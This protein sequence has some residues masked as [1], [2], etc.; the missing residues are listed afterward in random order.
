MIKIIKKLIKNE[1]IT[2]YAVDRIIRTL[3]KKDRKS[4]YE[5][6]KV[7]YKY[8]LDLE[9]E[10]MLYESENTRTKIPLY[11][12]FDKQRKDI[13]WSSDLYSFKVPS[14]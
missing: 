3:L 5:K 2:F 12:P 11:T 9:D 10:N 13:D 6:D 1:K 7:F 14:C 8:Y 4:F